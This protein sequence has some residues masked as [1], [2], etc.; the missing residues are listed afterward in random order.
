M[1]NAK[2]R[3][4][5]RFEDFQVDLEAGE[6]WKAG[7]RLKVQDQPFKIL[8][9]L[10]QRPGEIVT[11]EELRQLIWP[12]QSFGDFDHAINLAITKLRSTLGDSADVP[13]LI[14]TL[15]RRGYR[16]IAPLKEPN[17][18]PP[19][20]SIRPLEEPPD[21]GP[22]PSPQRPPAKASAKKLWL[23]SGGLVLILV[24]AAV[25]LKVFPRHREPSATADEL[26]PLVSMPG[27]QKD[28][29][30]S[31][32]GNQ[33]AFGYA[34]A[35]HPGIYT[36][37]IGGE[38]PLQL[39]EN[40]A[41]MDPAWSPD[42]RQIAFS[43]VDDA[44]R[45]ILYLIPALGGLPR[46]I[47]TSQSALA[48][49][50]NTM[51][52]SPDGKFLAFSEAL[53]NGA[54][55]RL[56][57]LSLADL[58]ARPLTS[59]RNQEFHCYP[60]FSPDGA[61]IAFASGPIGAVPGDLFV[62]NLSGGQPLRLTSGNSG[63]PPAWTQDGTEIIYSSSAKGASSLWRISASG[64]A[65]QRVAGAGADAYHPSISRRGNQLA[66]QALSLWDT[67]WRLGLKDERHALGPPVRLLSGRGGAWRPSYSPDGKKIAFESDRMGYSDIW[68]C[69][70]DGSNCVQLTSMHG[71]TGTARWSPDGRY[72]SF[73]SI[74]QDYYHIGLIEVPEG[75]P[76]LL[77]TFPG[78]NT[79]AP[80]WSRDGAWIYFY[81]SHDP[82]S[83][84]LWKMPVHGGPP[85]RVTTKGGVHG[86]ESSDGRFLYYAKYTEGGI[87]KRSLQTG[88]E[89]YL[90][91]KVYW[92][93]NW[94]LA[95]GGI[96][97]HNPTLQPY[98]SIDYF[99]FAT[100]QSTQVL[101]LE[102]PISDIG[103][104]AISPDGKSLLFGQ[105][106]R[107]DSYIMLLKNFH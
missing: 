9:A 96:Y 31:P 60:A 17:D 30:V 93:I 68:M 56:S 69:D 24:S 2:Q 13:H 49:H 53:E 38:K 12:E 51:S 87:W 43:R 73:E 36:A 101:A 72:L 33:V 61:S 92:W 58:T 37:V 39:T 70:S 63:G 48:H 88:E 78:T 19:E 22:Y 44:N 28:P 11:R 6:V 18:P 15:P 80:S 74:N 7:R 46:H 23:L 14:E 95:P 29:A 32:D 89:T 102:K 105:S 8:A 5:C 52:W 1:G 76:H 91:L 99:D 103:G 67:I 98:G 104:L 26:V 106:E 50:C 3:Q 62:V 100:G 42:G 4:I 35:P 66:Y 81:S 54:R 94:T 57:L 16:F 86:I 82:R 59:P 34:E 77:A 21:R 75:T 97:Y 10:L 27:L 84:E 55:V 41:D 45:K 65:P 64:G 90:P 25:W 20:H 107:L 71:I 47:Y 40:E 79:G 85:Q 83:F